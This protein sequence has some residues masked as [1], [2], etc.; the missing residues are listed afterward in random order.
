[1]GFVNTATVNNTIAIGIAAGIRLEAK[2][3]GLEY[4][5][6]KKRDTSLAKSVQIKSVPESSYPS[7]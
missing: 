1:M 6:G 3:F 2:G 7:L 4:R 5:Q